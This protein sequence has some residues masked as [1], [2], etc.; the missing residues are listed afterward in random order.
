[1]SGIKVSKQEDLI[2]SKKQT[3]TCNTKKIQIKTEMAE[4]EAIQTRLNP[5][6]IQA[7]AAALMIL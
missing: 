4:S 5:E 6:A 2:T 3:N 1:M 7:A